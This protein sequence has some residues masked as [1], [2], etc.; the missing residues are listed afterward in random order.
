MGV[1]LDYAAT[2]PLSDGMKAYLI[3]ILDDWGNPSSLMLEMKCINSY[4][5][6]HLWE[7]LFLLRAGLPQIL[8]QLKDGL[9]CDPTL[10]TTLPLHINQCSDVSKIYRARMAR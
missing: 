2:A 10:C 7:I 1:Y 9:L 8:W 4:T 6:N 5:L 3:S